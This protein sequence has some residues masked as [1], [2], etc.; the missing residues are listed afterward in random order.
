MWGKFSNIKKI[1]TLVSSISLN[2]TSI[3][4][5]K[6]ETTTLLAIV[7]PA[8]ASIKFFAWKSNNPSV[9]MVDQSGKVT[10]LSAGSAIIT[11]TTLD[12]S[13]ASASCNVTVNNTRITLSQAEASLPVNEIMTLT[14]TVIPSDIPVEWST[15][16]PNVAYIKKNSDKSVTVVGMA[17]G[18][19]TI[20]ASATDG[21][22]ASASC[23]VTVGVGGVEGIET[24]D[25][26][27]EVARYDIHGR[28]L[29]EPTRGINIVKFNNGTT[30]KEVVK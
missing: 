19:A 24:D 2:K 21:S 9:A 16:N 11:A 6:G 5:D 12:G 7:S 28:L 20:T 27:I 30:K 3:E 13:G 14:Y 23:V 10:A 1:E 25:N 15:S 17:D 22:G 8:D 4:L 29:T 26:A 18:G